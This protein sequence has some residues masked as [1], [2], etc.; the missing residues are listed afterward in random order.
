MAVVDIPAGLRARGVCQ[1]LSAMHLW[2]LPPLVLMQVDVRDAM[3]QDSQRIA[4]ADAARPG[5]G[6][7]AVTSDECSGVSISSSCSRDACGAGISRFLRM[8]FHRQVDAREVSL[9]VDCWGAERRT[10]G[11]F[12]PLMSLG[13]SGHEPAPR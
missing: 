9:C 12:P 11:G 5:P 7:E 8:E 4:Q 13:Y 2:Q 6:L 3:S 1:V 10:D